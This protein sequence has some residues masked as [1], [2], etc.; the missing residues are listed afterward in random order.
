MR[1]TLGVVIG[2]VLGERM[3]TWVPG[4]FF[5]R[6]IAMLLIILGLVMLVRQ[7]G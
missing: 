5:R 7:N 6:V 1:G 2:T 3:L 4:H